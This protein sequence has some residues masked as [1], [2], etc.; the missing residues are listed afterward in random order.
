MLKTPVFLEAYVENHWSKQSQ[1][2]R[3]CLVFRAPVPPSGPAL[4]T[5]LIPM[6]PQLQPALPSPRPGIHQAVSLQR[7]FCPLC[8]QYQQKPLLPETVPGHSG[9]KQ[10]PFPTSHDLQS[11]QIPP[12]A[13]SSCS[14]LKAPPAPPVSP[15]TVAGPQI[16]P[17]DAFQRRE[18]ILC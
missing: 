6:C 1:Q 16:L 14:L 18:S 3:Q 17:G 15:W 8:S 5:L 7:Y 12:L 11:Q 13:L 9:P 2:R 10:T 4:L